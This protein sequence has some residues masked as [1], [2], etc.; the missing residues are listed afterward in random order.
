MLC[1]VSILLAFCFAGISNSLIW[2]WIPVIL[3]AIGLLRSLWLGVHV[4]M[5]VLFVQLLPTF[6][7][8]WLAMNLAISFACCV[9]PSFSWQTTVHAQ[10]GQYLFNTQL[11]GRI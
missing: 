5:G 2:G 10:M 7:F 11:V 8:L 3:F 9:Q 1:S 4:S 6:Y